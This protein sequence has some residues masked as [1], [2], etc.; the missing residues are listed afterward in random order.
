MK[1]TKQERLARKQAKVDAERREQRH[2]EQIEYQARL[3]REVGEASEPAALMHQHAT[4]KL[5]VY[6]GRPAEGRRGRPAFTRTRNDPLG[7]YARR[8][9]ITRQ[10]QCA[11]KRLEQ[12]Y[13]AAQPS[14]IML[15]ERIGFKRH[16][17]PSERILDALASYWQA[18]RVLHPTQRGYVYSV[19]IESCR[20]EDLRGARRENIRTMLLD[21]LD[22]L[23]GHFG[24]G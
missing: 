5:S 6:F 12:L 14:S 10:Q 23:V 22:K 3:Q 1:L 11:G 18:M 17:E 2:R 4:G 20:I 24:Y 8:G 13:L 7:E 16:Y 15:M 19:C 9:M 21:G